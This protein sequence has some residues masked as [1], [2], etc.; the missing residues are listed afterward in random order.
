MGAN[1]EGANVEV[2]ITIVVQQENRG[3]ICIWSNVAR[4]TCMLM[5]LWWA[6]NNQFALEN[7]KISQ[8]TR[9]VYNTLQ[10]SKHSTR[11]FHFE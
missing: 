9:E 8:A 5:D 7:S 10:E 4:D 3:K 2:L 1:N 6:E 11:G